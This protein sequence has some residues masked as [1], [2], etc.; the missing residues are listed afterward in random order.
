MHKKIM[1]KKGFPLENPS[2]LLKTLAGQRRAAQGYTRSVYREC[3]PDES[4][5]SGRNQQDA[6][7]G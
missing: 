5:R 3:I 7:A 1:H 6:G 2:V 4:T